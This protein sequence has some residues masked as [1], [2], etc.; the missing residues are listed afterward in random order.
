MNRE[1]A[2]W[3][4]Q[5]TP[6][7][8]ILHTSGQVL[9]LS[10][11]WMSDNL[12]LFYGSQRFCFAFHAFSWKFAT[13]LL[14]LS[15]KWLR[16]A[17]HSNTKV[18]VPIAARTTRRQTMKHQHC[19]TQQRTT[20]TRASVGVFRTLGLYKVGISFPNRKSCTSFSEG[21]LTKWI[22]SHSDFSWK[23]SLLLLICTALA[24]MTL[25][26]G[27]MYKTLLWTFKVKPDVSCCFHRV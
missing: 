11:I 3:R 1:T 21:V 24:R 10:L 23:K 14:Y 19:S 16:C 4:G 8:T 7:R 13:V 27:L 9:M 12:L 6:W 18:V 26:G 5:E 20:V 15:P 2:T 25:Y 17:E 22:P